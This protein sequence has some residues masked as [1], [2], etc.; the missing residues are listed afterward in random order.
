MGREGGMGAKATHTMAH[1]GMWPGNPTTPRRHPFLFLCC[2]NTQSM[3]TVTP[4]QCRLP[5]GGAAYHSLHNAKRKAGPCKANQGAKT[6]NSFV[7]T[8]LCTPEAEGDW[9]GLAL[10]EGLAL[11]DSA[12]M[13]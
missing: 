12:A 13:A 11:G 9:L 1:Q 5:Y 8:E 3:V 2:I 10:A 6:S 7:C 4:M